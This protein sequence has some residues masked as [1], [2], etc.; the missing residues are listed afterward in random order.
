MH[1][2]GDDGNMR[3]G[4][5]LQRLIAPDE[6]LNA[7]ATNAVELRAAEPDG[8]ELSDDKL[9][10]EEL[11]A[12]DVSAEELNGEA[13]G[14]KWGSALKGLGVGELDD[15]DHNTGWQWGTPTTP[16]IMVGHYHYS[17]AACRGYG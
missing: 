11:S 7:E 14:A 12:E 1:H 5:A 4:V 6:E 13:L 9:I 17:C 3:H 15:E 8:G 16:R 2:N 10:A